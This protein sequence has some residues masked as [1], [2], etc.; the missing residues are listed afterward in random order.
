MRE[1]STSLAPALPRS[2]QEA[3]QEGGSPSPTTLP[4]RWA[5]ERWLSA[6]R[7]PAP[8]FMQGE[9]HAST[10]PLLLEPSLWHKPAEGLRTQPGSASATGARRMPPRLAQPG[11]AAAPAPGLC[12]GLVW[13]EALH[14]FNNRPQESDLGQDWNSV[15]QRG[16]WGPRAAAQ[17]RVS[18]PTSQ[19]SPGPLPF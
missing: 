10:L 17:P 13:E 19:A 2:L 6:S 3:P 12:L 18:T 15:L 16:T 1:E 9:S 14:V 8:T 4:R 5:S 7:Q 11:T